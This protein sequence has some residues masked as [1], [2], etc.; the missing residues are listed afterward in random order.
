MRVIGASQ[1]YVGIHKV[2][3]VLFRVV[4]GCIIRDQL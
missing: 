4:W 3:Q 1:G 2:L